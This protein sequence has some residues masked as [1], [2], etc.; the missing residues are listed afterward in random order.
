MAKENDR[1]RRE[2]TEKRD[3]PASTPVPTR[4]SAPVPPKAPP[5]RLPV[6]PKPRYVRLANKVGQ[7]V[8][9]SV[10]DDSGRAVEIRLGARETSRPVREDRLTEYT[11]GLIQRGHLRI[12]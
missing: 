9:A 1:G 12:G 6:L 2:V 4:T 7:L 5:S 11:R 10:V 3:E 8:T